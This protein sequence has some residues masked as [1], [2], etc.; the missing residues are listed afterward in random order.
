VQGTYCPPGPDPNHNAGSSGP[1]SKGFVKPGRKVMSHIKTLG[2]MERAT[3]C[4]RARETRHNVRSRGL[5]TRGQ[6]HLGQPSDF[7]P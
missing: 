2:P 7:S 3:S 5:A 6:A 1:R 4:T